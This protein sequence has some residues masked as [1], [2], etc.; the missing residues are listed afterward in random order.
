M[1][2]VNEYGG[3][4]YKALLAYDDQ[5]RKAKIHDTT[6]TA[7]IQWPKRKLNS[8]RSTKFWKAKARVE[9]CGMLESQANY[10]RVPQGPTDVCGQVKSVC[11]PY[12]SELLYP[13]TGRET[14]SGWTSHRESVQ[15]NFA[16]PTGRGQNPAVPNAH[17]NTLTGKFLHSGGGAIIANVP[18]I[19]NLHTGAYLT[20]NTTRNTASWLSFS[21]IPV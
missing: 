3:G 2:Y 10:K 19:A 11:R 12:Q 6:N 7:G 16:E 15:P 1:E 4:I 13:L 5:C 9:D 14:E 21:C 20:R 18:S 17:R 8:R